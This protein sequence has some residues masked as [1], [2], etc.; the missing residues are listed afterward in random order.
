MEQSRSWRGALFF[1]S[2][3]KEILEETKAV[4]SNRCI[5]Y[6]VTL[7]GGKDWT[8]MIARETL[9][10]KDVTKLLEDLKRRG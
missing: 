4:A 3:Q 9:N 10:E 7:C 5:F 6:Y 2:A 8:K 1:P